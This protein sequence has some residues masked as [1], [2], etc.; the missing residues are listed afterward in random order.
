ME[1]IQDKAGLRTGTKEPERHVLRL[2]Q[3]RLSLI[4]MEAAIVLETE[5]KETN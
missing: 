3:Q 1:K 5:G 2:F 4:T